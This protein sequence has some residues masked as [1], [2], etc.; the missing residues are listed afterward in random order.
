MLGREEGG[1]LELKGR[2]LWL[3][4]ASS[5][6]GAAVAPRLAQE[7]SILALSARRE[8]ELG[9]VANACPGDVRPLV[10][11]L[12]VTDSSQIDRVYAE[13]TEAWGKVDIVFYNAG[14]WSQTTADDFDADSA[15]AQ[16]DVV[17]LGLIRVAGKV[18]PDMVKRRSGCIIGMSSIAG[19]AG[20]VRAPVYSSAKNGVTA[21]LQAIRMELKRYGISVVTISPGFVKTRLTDQNDFPMPFRISPEQAADHIMEG[22]RKG[23]DEIHFPWTM[24][25]PAKVFTAL[26]RPVYEYL[27]RLFLAR[28]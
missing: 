15:L 10:K 28:R 20:I 13:L 1:E 22:L 6:I 25:L 8:E 16:I 18:M 26:P 21:F 4:G 12:D 2:T 17:Y 11:P 23:D 27:S 9:E 3:I 14:T 24:S 19:Y 7:G 5:G